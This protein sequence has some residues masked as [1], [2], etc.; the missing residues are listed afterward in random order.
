M[1][2]N[3]KTAEKKEGL[4]SVI[5]AQYIVCRQFTLAKFRALYYR[6]LCESGIDHVLETAKHKNVALL[7][8][9]DPLGATTHTDMLLRARQLN[10]QTQVVHN[11]SIMNAVSCCG[12]QLYNFGE[13]VSI[14]YWTPTWRPQSFFE[15]ILENYKR[16]L[17]TLCLLDIKVR[18]P[19]EESL[20]KKKRQYM[21]PRFMSVKEAASQLVNIIEL[22]NH[23]E[24]ITKET[25]AV[26]LARVGTADQQ[27]VVKS[28]HEMQHVD[29]GPPLHSLVIPAPNL[30]PIEIDFLAQFEF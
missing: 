8:V 30:H 1:A 18:E 17:H 19:T 6:E 22:Q 20:T 3:R 26:G 15:K 29:L 11:A 14:P 13:T 2:R 5:P 24:Y 23:N 27:I 25:K 16:N 4:E 9:G 7:V 10:V 28:L 12:L 21:D